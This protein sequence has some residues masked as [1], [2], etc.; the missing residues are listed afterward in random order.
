V[1]LHL[2]GALNIPAGNLALILLGLAVRQVRPRI[3]ALPVTFGAVGLLG[4]L[5][6]PPLVALTGH[7]GGAAERIA[8]YPLIVW[9][10]GLGLWLL[11]SRRSLSGPEHQVR[12]A[13]RVPT[14]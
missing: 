9:M 13:E 14:G 11:C 4:L 8:L 3:A 5:A 10:I 1:V 12:A 6:G 2:V 7:G